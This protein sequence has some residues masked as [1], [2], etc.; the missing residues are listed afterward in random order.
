MPCEVALCVRRPCLAPVSLNEPV[1][2][3]IHTLRVAG[4]LGFLS[5][6]WAIVDIKRA[7]GALDVCLWLLSPASP[8]LCAFVL[9]PL[10]L[11]VN[12]PLPVV[13]VKQAAGASSVLSCL[14]SLCLFLVTAPVALASRFLV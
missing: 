1:M 6:A 11:L 4:C 14:T 8:L 7:T 13:M 3:G 12:V 9:T 5:Q 2:R 10:S